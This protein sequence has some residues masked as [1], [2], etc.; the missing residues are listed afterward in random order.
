MPWHGR[1]AMG[2]LP[3]AT[4]P[5][6]LGLSYELSEKGPE[7]KRTLLVAD[8][9]GFQRRAHDQIDFVEGSIRLILNDAQRIEAFIEQREKEVQE[10]VHYLGRDGITRIG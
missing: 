9:D 4:A 10:L 6:L 5:R 2:E 1:R 8:G 3:V 7:G